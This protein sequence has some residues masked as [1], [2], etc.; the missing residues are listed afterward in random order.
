VIISGS[1]LISAR[2]DGREVTANIPVLG[3][4]GVPNRLALNVSYLAEY[5]SNKDGIVSMSWT[6]G[7]APVSFQHKNTPKVIIM[8]MNAQWDDEQ[9]ATQ[10][11][12]EVLP[13]EPETPEEVA[14][15]ANPDPQEP[16]KTPATKKR[17]N[18]KEK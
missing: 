5:L 15:E 12:A 2:A 4:K 9:P 3:A 18:R 16:V 7:S 13:E 11:E 6:G 10:L 14:P 8:P 1:P 17:R